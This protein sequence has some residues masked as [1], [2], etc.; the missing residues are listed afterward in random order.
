VA[1]AILNIAPGRNLT[2]YLQDIRKFATL[3][4]EENVSLA[5]RWRDSQ[6]MAANSRVTIARAEMTAI[7]AP[8]AVTT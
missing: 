6:D 4:H 5:P 7:E 1:S 2:R 3:T 8:A